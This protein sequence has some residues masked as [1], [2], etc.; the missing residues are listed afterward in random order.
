MAKRR[1]PAKRAPEPDWRHAVL[2]QGRMALESL[3]P[4]SWERDALDWTA[5]RLRRI[6]GAIRGV[7]LGLGLFWISLGLLLASLYFPQV[8]LVLLFIT[9]AVAVLF[10][11]WFVSW[12]LRL[13]SRL[14][15][16]I[17]RV[18]ELAEMSNVERHAHVARR[19]RR[20]R[21]ARG[22]RGRSPG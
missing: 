15:R 4:E 12:G 16:H 2:H 7:F 5:A 9:A 6:R 14:S 19:L 1:R 18:D 3:E 20:R 21:D 8:R 11:L 13:G 10:G 22:A 17:D